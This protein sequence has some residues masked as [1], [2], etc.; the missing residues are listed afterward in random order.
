M[1]DSPLGHC[2]RPPAVLALTAILAAALLVA[3][4]A[5]GFGLSGTQF[6]EGLGKVGDALKSA[7]EAERHG[8]SGTEQFVVDKGGEIADKATDAIEQASIKLSRKAADALKKSDS[9]RVG[10][11][12]KKAFKRWG[13]AVRKGLR[14]AGPVGRVVDTADAGYTAGSA[15]G[16]HVVVPLMDMFYFDGKSR[17]LEEQILSDMKEI[18]K[19]G[20]FSRR[21][22]EDIAAYQREA[23]A[24]EE[25]ERALYRPEGGGATSAPN[26]GGT[27]HDP[28]SPA[29]NEPNPWGSDVASNERST[30]PVDDKEQLRYGPEDSGDASDPWSEDESDATRDSLVPVASNVPDPWGQDDATFEDQRWSDQEPQGDW[31][32]DDDGAEAYAAALAN[33]LDESTEHEAEEDDYNSA[34]AALERL[35]AQRREAEER[36]AQR[37]LELDTENR[38][39]EAARL[40]AQQEARERAAEKVREATKLNGQRDAQRQESERPQTGEADHCV[41][42]GETFTRECDWGWAHGDYGR[43]VFNT[44]SKPIYFRYRTVTGWVSDQTIYPKG[45]SEV[46][47]A[48]CTIDGTPIEFEYVYCAQFSKEF[49]P[50]QFETPEDSGRYIKQYHLVLSA[51]PCYKAI[52]GDPVPNRSNFLQFRAYSINRGSILF[53]YDAEPGWNPLSD[54]PEPE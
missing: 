48:P 41:K 21:L 17:E 34:L 45:N 16:E 50:D 30:L 49:E 47:I 13:P 1:F 11:L 46:V 2:R 7:Q 51:S 26:A 22:D 15:I 44:C 40:K 3:A 18:R 4:P 6:V 32:A 37:I 9:K 43:R 53:R 54:L 19:R 29:S 12:A 42:L 23:R 31:T 25:E 5:H 8:R 24:M 33:V 28:W 52:V 20:E 36:E 27:E 39:R 38:R 10:E 14:M 35:D